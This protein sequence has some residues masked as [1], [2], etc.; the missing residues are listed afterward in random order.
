MPKSRDYVVARFEMDG[1][2]QV[3]AE[4]ARSDKSLYSLQTGKTALVSTEMARGLFST[5]DPK[6]KYLYFVSR[7]TFDPSSGISSS[8]TSSAPP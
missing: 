7:R 1:L 6:G 8:T 3:R 2:R 4:T 5:W